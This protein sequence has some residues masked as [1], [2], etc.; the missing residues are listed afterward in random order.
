MIFKDI[1]ALEDAIVKMLFSK[2][3][4]KVFCWIQ[5]RRIGRKKVQLHIF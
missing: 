5:L 4:P 1:N 2:L 3:I